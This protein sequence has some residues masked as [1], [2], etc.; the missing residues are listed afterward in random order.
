MLLMFYVAASASSGGELRKDSVATRFVYSENGHKVA[1][2]VLNQLLYLSD[3]TYRAN[4]SFHLENLP[5]FDEEKALELLDKIAIELIDNYQVDSLEVICLTGSF[6]VFADSIK[7]LAT[8]SL[9]P[10]VMYSRRNLSG[11]LNEYANS[12]KSGRQLVE[13]FEKK[14]YEVHAAT[15]EMK[16]RVNPNAGVSIFAGSFGFTMKKKKITP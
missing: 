9:D 3:K 4:V 2:V 11:L 7:R 6:D 15:E 10:H 14:G 1:G 13:R 12:L 5:D 8:K 16:I